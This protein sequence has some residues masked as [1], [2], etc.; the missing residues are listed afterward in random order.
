VSRLRALTLLFLC[1]VAVGGFALPST[2]VDP[3][4]NGFLGGA[5]MLAYGLDRS[6]LSLAL[7]A[8]YTLPNRVGVG[9]TWFFTLPKFALG[10]F[11]LDGRYVMDTDP[12]GF[13]AMVIPM[14][15]RLGVFG[16]SIGA[17]FAIGL[18][19]YAYSLY[20]SGDMFVSPK[21]E[22]ELDYDFDTVHPWLEAGVSAEGTVGRPQGNDY[23][24]Y[25]YY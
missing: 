7:E 1:A 3:A 17:G 18:Q 19:Y 20:P 16:G 25:Y 13:G 2:F 12:S 14:K 6:E 9:L 10:S 5:V 21:F 11:S 4:N 23:I 24:V 8:S 22:F 15:L